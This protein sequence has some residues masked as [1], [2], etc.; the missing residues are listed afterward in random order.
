MGVPVVVLTGQLHRQRVGYSILK[1]ANIEETIAYS[2]D[3][4]IA[5]AV[6]L[7]KD[8]DALMRLRRDI[9]TRLR[10][11]I[12][13]DPAHF[14]RQLEEAYLQAWNRLC[15]GKNPDPPKRIES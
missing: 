13:C 15:G 7:A 5:T 1:N 4:Y 6:R 9:H 14:T 8:H 11:S 12:L 3:E 10:A 2:E